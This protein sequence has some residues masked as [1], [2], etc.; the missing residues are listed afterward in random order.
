[1]FVCINHKNR[2]ADFKVSVNDVIVVGLCS[3]C[4]DELHYKHSHITVAVTETSVL[5]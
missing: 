3:E 1:M 2:V 4:E 5:N